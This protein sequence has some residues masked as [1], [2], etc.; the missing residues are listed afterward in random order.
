MDGVHELSG[1]AHKGRVNF[2]LKIQISSLEQD[3]GSK[4][5]IERKCKIVD[6]TVRKNVVLFVFT[7]RIQMAANS[8]E[9]KLH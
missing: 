6:K 9:T 5:K 7:L 4:T 3:S 8:P 2:L 1:N